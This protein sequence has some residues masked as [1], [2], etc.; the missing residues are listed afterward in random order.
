MIIIL[1]VYMTKSYNE[2]RRERLK[3]QIDDR[4]FTIL[5]QSLNPRLNIPKPNPVSVT[6]IN[7]SEHVYFPSVSLNSE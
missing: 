2:I 4:I 7:I 3:P 1:Y 5:N 6:V